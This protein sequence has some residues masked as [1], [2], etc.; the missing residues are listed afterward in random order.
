MSVNSSARL[1][2]WWFRWIPG[3]VLLVALSLAALKIGRTVLL[4]LVVSFALAF[5]LEPFVDWLE[6]RQHSRNRA[7]LLSMGVAVLAITFLLIFLVPSIWAQLGES[8][9]KLP[10]ALL[11]IAARG[12]L[13]MVWMHDHL[14]PALFQRLQAALE[15]FEKDPSALTSH[16][17]AWL[18]RGAF[19][20][21]GAGSAAL[22]LIVVPFFVYYLLL[23]MHRL[24]AR[25]ESH[26]PARHRA[27]ASNLLN[28][29]GEVMRSYVRGRVLMAG[30]MAAIYATGLVILQVPLWAA[31]GIIAGIF[32]IIPYLGVLC[33]L[34]L[35]LGFAALKGATVWH[36]IGVGALF[37]VAQLVEDYVLTPRLIGNKL[38]LHPM[39]V[40]IA[41]I[42][43]GD[44][45]GLF[46][47]LLAVPA[48]A[49]LKVLVGALDKLYLQTEFFSHATRQKEETHPAS[50]GRSFPLNRKEALI[51][52]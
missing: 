18:S 14:S 37:G 45:F 32:G 52:L 42:I 4:P 43:G 28:E 9:E 34:V 24:R 49:V 13:L 1:Q 3:V 17:G 35:A 39:L 29:I 11:A 41:L 33:G 36:L 40:L 26:I 27:A 8:L 10:L 6:R 19:G 25:I 2:F 47:L 15:Q 51:L 50:E 30:I 22:G 38:E 20:L 7:V 44:L 46:G 21:V 48:F 5:M 16:F 31:I 12:K 23:D